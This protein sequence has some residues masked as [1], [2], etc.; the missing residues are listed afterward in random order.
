MNFTGGVL[1]AGLTM[2]A[3]SF[4][5]GM[6]A[7]SASAAAFNRSEL[8]AH[9]AEV[10][11]PNDLDPSNPCVYIVV[12]GDSESSISAATGKSQQGIAEENH[13]TKGKAVLIPGMKID[14]C[15]NG[16]D[17]I[18][19]S[20][21][22]ATT[23]TTTPQ[24][25]PVTNAKECE[26][27]GNYPKAVKALPAFHTEPATGTPNQLVI[28]ID[29]SSHVQTGRLTLMGLIDYDYNA[30]T[31]TCA[32]DPRDS[33]D[34]DITFTS[35][36]GVNPE[37]T[38]EGE[39]TIGAPHNTTCYKHDDGTRAC[40][41]KNFKSLMGKDVR[42]GK[43]LN[44]NIGLHEIPNMIQKGMDTNYALTHIDSLPKMHSEARLKTAVSSACIRESVAVNNLI[45]EYYKTAKILIHA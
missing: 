30:A 7:E 1:A 39:F 2:S 19:G 6:G 18:H 3:A 15:L 16:M 8:P 42:T 45:D 10:P 23:S 26:A 4:M 38:P 27:R 21:S 32:Q 36:D 22:P 13:R 11:A 24:S 41:L 29:K 9:V 34:F 33:G 28:T 35:Y 12:P 31:G 43:S 40:V 5:P 44:G 37:N 17:D 20:T 14:F 25:A